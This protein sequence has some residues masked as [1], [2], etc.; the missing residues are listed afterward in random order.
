MRR[1]VRISIAPLI[2]SKE[3]TVEKAMN[4]GAHYPAL[5]S[6]LPLFTPEQAAADAELA[7]KQ[8]HPALVERL[9]RDVEIEATKTR[10]YLSEKIFD[11]VADYLEELNSSKTGAYSR[12]RASDADFR[13]D[14]AIAARAVLSPVDYRIFC[15]I[16]INCIKPVSSITQKRLLSIKRIIGREF[17]K[18]NLS[19]TH[20]YFSAFIKEIKQ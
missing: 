10:D 19:N 6:I 18:R 4:Y 7:A 11:T 2:F 20:H 17:K 13:S 5:E 14:C 1:I 16:W 8:E 3:A 12:R 15:D 9:I